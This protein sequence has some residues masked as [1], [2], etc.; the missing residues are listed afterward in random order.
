MTDVSS[1]T[2]GIWLHNLIWGGINPTGL[3]ENYWYA[4]Y[5]IYNTVKLRYQFRSITLL[6]KIFL[7]IM[8]NM[9]PQQRLYLFPR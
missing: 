2:Q 6:S 8:E 1:D 4:K 7:L 9:W 3:I 5:H